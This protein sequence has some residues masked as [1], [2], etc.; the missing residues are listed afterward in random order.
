MLRNKILTLLTEKNIFI[1]DIKKYANVAKWMFLPISTTQSRMCMVTLHK[2]KAE[3]DN[4]IISEE[5]KH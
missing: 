2:G 3:V 4:Q 5:K 1:L